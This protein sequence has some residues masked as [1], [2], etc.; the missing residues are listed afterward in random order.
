MMNKNETATT[1]SAKKHFTAIGLQ[2]SRE[3]RLAKADAPSEASLL[4]V[5]RSERLLGGRRCKGGREERPRPPQST[6]RLS[7]EQRQGGGQAEAGG[8]N[9]ARK[10][11]T[12]RKTGGGEKERKRRKE[13]H[14]LVLPVNYYF[15][16]VYNRKGREPKCKL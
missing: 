14:S 8:S 2:T 11:R 10:Q 4:L 7:E 5:S 16:Y 6:T 9:A 12:Q 3:V 13:K 1:S 15:N